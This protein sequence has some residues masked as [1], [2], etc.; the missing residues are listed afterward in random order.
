MLIYFDLQG[1][2]TE[3]VTFRS[4]IIPLHQMA[5][6]SPARVVFMTPL[7]FGIAHFHHFYEFRLMHPYANLTSSLVRT[8]FQFTYTT[9]F[10]WFAAFVYL[11]TASLLADIII[12]SFWNYCGLPRLW[13][14]VDG[15]LVIDPSSIQGKEA[16]DNGHAHFYTAELS[17]GLTVAYYVLMVA[18]AICFYL[19][20]WPLTYSN[21][22][23]VSC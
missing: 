23:L 5:K 19:K 3:E 11:R 13:G 22:E 9:I 16:S 10:G 7:Y 17:I 12:H 1:P 20:L 18:G 14:R 15:P 8:L 4:V 6:V 21:R 2:V